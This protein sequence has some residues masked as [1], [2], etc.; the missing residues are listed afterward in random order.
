MGSQRYPQHLGATTVLQTTVA[1]VSIFAT[2]HSEW[3]HQNSIYR[4]HSFFCCYITSTRYISV[5]ASDM[6]IAHQH[7]HFSDQ[8]HSQMVFF[9]MCGSIIAYHKLCDYSVNECHVQPL[10]AM[11]DRSF[12][13]KCSMKL[14]V[15]RLSF[16]AVWLVIC[17]SYI[18]Y[19]KLSPHKSAIFNGSYTRAHMST[20]QTLI[21]TKV[22]G[23]G[24]ADIP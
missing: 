21:S 22:G 15:A 9:W 17:W 12:V 8:L 5:P 7:K 24:W 11:H 13:L 6:A 14:H 19:S 4:S 16:M 23:G 2:S 10:L 1:A 3:Q 18:D 20:H